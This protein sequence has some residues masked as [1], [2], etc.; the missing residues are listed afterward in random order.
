GVQSRC[1]PYGVRFLCVR[2]GVQLPRERLL[3]FLVPELGLGTLVVETPF[4]V[5]PG[6]SGGWHGGTAKLAPHRAKPSPMESGSC[7]R[8]GGLSSSPRP[9][10]AP[11]RGDC[12]SSP[13]WCTWAAPCGG[14]TSPR[15]SPSCPGA[16]VPGFSGRTVP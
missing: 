8:V 16:V 7:G 5:V 2:W 13:R 1:D 12:S 4:P 14:T 9:A 15:R 11:E 6:Y 10:R 3:F